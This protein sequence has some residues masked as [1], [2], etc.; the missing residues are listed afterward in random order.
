MKKEGKSIAAGETGRTNSR[1]PNESNVPKAIKEGKFIVIEGIDGAGSTTQAKMLVDEL[2]YRDIP[3][4]Y[5]H[6][7]TNLPTGLLLR[8]ILEKKTGLTYSD[9]GK[10][11]W[12]AMALLFAADRVV[13]CELIKK[14]L[15][16]G[17]WVI[18]DRFLLS[19][20]AYQ[21]LCAVDA[22]RDIESPEYTARDFRHYKEAHD[23][24]NQ[25][26]CFALAPD[27]TYVLHVSAEWA[28]EN[29]ERR[30]SDEDL[31]ENIEFQKR[32]ASEYS[33]TSDLLLTSNHDFIVVPGQRSMLEV[34]KSI[35]SR[36]DNTF[37]KY[38]EI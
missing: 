12:R 30:G 21:G 23:W 17:T 13:H 3:A 38:L 28:A 18:S 24:I 20:L 27:M 31:F 22:Q 16:S 32:L 6:E 1:G 26:N 7:P 29:R 14:H 11:D 19:S 34:H 15:D 37:E 35:L 33:A 25:I 8:S 4:V 9:T 2:N 36:V 10:H 5:A